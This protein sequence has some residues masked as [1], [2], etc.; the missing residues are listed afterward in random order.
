MTSLPTAIL[1]PDRVYR[2][3]LVRD[4]PHFTGP[5][6][7]HAVWLLCNPSTASETIDDHTVRKGRGFSA[8]WGFSSMEFVNRAAYRSRHPRE[9]LHVEDP[10]G[11]DNAAHLTAA[12]ER[13]DLVIFAWGLAWPTKLDRLALIPDVPGAMC[14]GRTKSGAPCH[15]LMLKYD[16]PLQPWTTISP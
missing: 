15:P 7:G 3:S 12:F 10:I 9:L 8:L 11:P 16:T 1:S 2:Y 6:R 13:A 14:L 4:V 5:D